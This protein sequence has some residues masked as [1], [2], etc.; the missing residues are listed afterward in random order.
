MNKIING[1]VFIVFLAVVVYWIGVWAPAHDK[2]VQVSGD[3]YK[4]CIA[5]EYHT[6]PEAC[7]EMAGG[8]GCVC[9]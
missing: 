5:R 7:A 1:C 6:T 9:Q 3:A 2:A 4:A 8:I